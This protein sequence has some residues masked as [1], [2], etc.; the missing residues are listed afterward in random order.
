MWLSVYL[1]RVLA[2]NS[3]QST[4]TAKEG[5]HNNPGM[6]VTVWYL[7]MTSKVKGDDINRKRVVWMVL[8]QISVN[9]NIHHVPKKVPLYFRLYLSHF[10]VD[11][12]NSYTNGTGMNTPESH[13]IYLLN[14][15]MTSQV[16]HVAS[17]DSL[18]SVYMLKS[19]ILSLKINF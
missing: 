18:I 4:N 8:Y 9:S 5:I 13:K 17:C 19:T 6:A 7:L 3:Q 11:F 14:R 15:L 1:L 10:L 2:N 16:R 12:Y